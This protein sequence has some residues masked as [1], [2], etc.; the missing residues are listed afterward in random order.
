MCHGGGGDAFAES[1]QGVAG[2]PEE[3]V[4]VAVVEVRQ[5]LHGGLLSALPG[6][7]PPPRRQ[8]RLGL[9]GA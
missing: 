5:E 1:L 9:R 2:D 8:V 4:Q 6:L 7:P 3:R